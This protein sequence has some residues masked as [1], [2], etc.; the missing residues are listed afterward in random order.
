MFCSPGD[1]RLPRACA[2]STAVSKH[3]SAIKP[4]GYHANSCERM[5]LI[6]RRRSS[7]VEVH[8]SFIS[9][10]SLNITGGHA[11]PFAADERNCIALS[12]QI[13]SGVLYSPYARYRVAAVGS[14]FVAYFGLLKQSSS[15]RRRRRREMRQW[16]FHLRG[17]RPAT[18]SAEHHHRIA[19]RGGTARGR[20]R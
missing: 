9:K 17:G 18:A 20:R 1:I 14:K 12:P 19:P 11:T 5:L 16:H 4:E 15:S 8:G 7:S 13:I 10:L 6:W 3:G 2:A